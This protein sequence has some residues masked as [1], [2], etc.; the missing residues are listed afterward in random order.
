MKSGGTGGSSTLT[1]LKFEK[2]TDIEKFIKKFSEYKVDHGKV[3][4]KNKLVALIFKK[5]DLYVFLENNGI[6]WDERISRKLLPDNCVYVFKTKKLFIIEVKYQQTAGSVDEKLQTCSFKL[7]QYKRLFK[8]TGIS[9]EYSYILGDYFKQEK[10]KDVLNY[11][12]E[13]NCS[14]VY[15]EAINIRDYGLTIPRMK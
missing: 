10:Y 11:I 7:R 1:G 15:Y 9:V 2:K 4:Y 12:K 13:C 5:H 8:G 14:Y 6:K 3:F